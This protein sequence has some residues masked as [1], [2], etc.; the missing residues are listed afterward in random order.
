M[1]VHGQVGF[2]MHHDSFISRAIAW[3][4][5]SRWSHSFMV[6]DTSSKQSYTI[7]TSDFRIHNGN[8]G[9]YVKNKNV[10]LEIWDFPLDDETRDRMTAAC[11]EFHGHMYGY[12]QLFSLGI[13]RLL[14]R[15]GITIPNF[16]RHSV[17]CNQLVS[18]GLKE[19]G[20]KPFSTLDPESIDT[21]ELYQLVTGHK[22]AVLVY[23]KERGK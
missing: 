10:S 14:M 22:K 12:A 8:V 9:S 19:S 7:E 13:R 1:I 5:G 23:K 11:Q 21:E 15:V 16:I 18:Y 4:M 17:V 6:Y 2:C 20:L 3:F